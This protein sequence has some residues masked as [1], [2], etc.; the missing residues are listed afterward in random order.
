MCLLPFVL[1]AAHPLSYGSI[2]SE[3]E[4]AAGKEETIRF[5]VF[6]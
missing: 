1:C 3:E 4:K 6:D 2:Y 5:A